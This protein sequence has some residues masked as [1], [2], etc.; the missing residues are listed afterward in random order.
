MWI[1]PTDNKA[2]LAILNSKMGW[3]LISKFCTQIQNGYQLIWKYFG[4]IPIPDLSTCKELESYA[5]N[6]LSKSKELMLF[7]K[8]FQK[9]LAAQFNKIS[10]NTKLGV[11]Y[12]LS[13]AEFIKELHKQKINLTLS[14]QSE[15]LSFF[16]QEKQTA[17]AIKNEIDR[18][19]KKIDYM[20]YALYGL[21]DEEIKIVEN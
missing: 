11:W 18:T 13:F 1:I 9:L 8:K 16:E 12:N 10:I 17:I 15:W 21:T 3:W 6:I 19:D 14:Q 2:I 5:E 4:Q 7:N 20:V